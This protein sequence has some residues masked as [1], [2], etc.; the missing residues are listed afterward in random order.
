MIGD[1]N[2]IAARVKR[3]IPWGWWNLLPP[4][5]DAVIGGLSDAAAW[6][7]TWISYAKLQARI[8]TSSG[9]WLD[10]IA[11]DFFGRYLQRNG[12]TDGAFLARIKATLL[13]ERVTR[14]GMISALTA[15]T[16]YAPA[17]FEPWNAR[18]TGAY[19]IGTLGYGAAGGWGSL[20]LPGQVFITVPVGETPGV[21]NVSGYGS[22]AAGYGV[23]ILEYSGPSLSPGGV[24]DEDIY[25]TI[26]ATKPTGTIAWTRIG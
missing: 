3:V 2:D 9:P 22:S 4:L 15:L 17:I 21:P 19:G 10:L 20:Q 16:G 12:A 14:A 11:L 5:R 18:D 7:Y 23:G 13:Q 6:C 24:T 25:A 26:L 8:T 1:S